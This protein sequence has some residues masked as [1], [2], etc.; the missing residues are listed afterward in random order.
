MS[1]VSSVVL[2]AT[3]GQDCAAMHELSLALKWPHR[4]TDLERF[5]RLGHGL[6]AETEDGSVVGSVMWW[7]WGDS[8]ATLGLMM[9]A[10]QA[11]GQKIG[12]RLMEA[13]HA[14]I[15]SRTVAL[16][17]TQSG[18]ALYEKYGYRSTG[19]IEQRQAIIGTVGLT[20]LP[21]GM[22]LRPAGRNDRDRIVACDAAATGADRS[23]LIDEL[24]NT[25]DV[26]ILDHDGDIEGFSFCYRFGR[27]LCVGPCIAT[28]RVAATSLIG[29]WLS[30]HSGQFLRI[31]V[32]GESGLG[33]WLDEIGLPVVD[34]GTR[35]VRGS[36][37]PTSGSGRRFSLCSQ[38]FG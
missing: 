6:I 33:P 1:A 13:A 4:L 35:M 10:E 24:L 20:A 2:R 38:A 25:S 26:I 15:G 14:A 32:T 30:S 5:E 9:V 29:H 22:R 23:A 17:A 27:G 28:S 34:V 16:N 36:L 12:S 37:P 21:D 3:K 7:P 31:D 8:F 19:T 11:R 18:L